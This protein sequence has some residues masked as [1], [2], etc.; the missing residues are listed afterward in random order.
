M[1]LPYFPK[2]TYYQTTNKDQQTYLDEYT[3]FPT[4]SW[5][6]YYHFTSPLSIPL[7]NNQEDNEICQIQLH[8]LTTALH[9]NKFTTIGLTQTRNRFVAQKAN[10]FSINHCD[11]AIARYME[12]TF[13]EDDENTNPQLTEKFFIKSQNVFVIFCMNENCDN[14][15]STALSD[16]KAY[17][18]FFK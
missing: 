12:D 14:I 18:S 2:Y 9:E 13:S 1:C 15:V 11:H 16:T 6:S 17:D 7:Y 8:N 5:T 10:R 3:L 4:Y